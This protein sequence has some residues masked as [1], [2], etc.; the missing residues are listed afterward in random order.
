MS[1]YVK[2]YYP[3]PPIIN[4]VIQYQNIN[5]DPNLRNLITHFYLKKAIKWIKN[6][7]EFN[8]AKKLLPKLE[9]KEGFDIIYKLI[10]EFTK[11]TDAN[12]YDLKKDKYHVMKEYLKYKLTK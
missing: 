9:S 1:T 5:N 6:Y 2:K 4:S 11:N 8:N 12:W 7:S 10:K 3:P